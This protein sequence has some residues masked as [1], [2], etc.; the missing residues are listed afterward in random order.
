MQGNKPQ[1]TKWHISQLRI[2]W[3]NSRLCFTIYIYIWY[4]YYKVTNDMI[5]LKIHITSIPFLKIRNWYSYQLWIYCYELQI[6]WWY[7]RFFL[8][9]M[10]CY[11]YVWIFIMISY[12]TIY[13]Q[14]FSYAFNY[15]S[16][17]LLFVHLYY[18][19]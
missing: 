19:I 14:I 6:Q 7:V 2:C 12:K 16:L 10:L 1:I 5:L 15:V 4:K 8:V 17:L 18:S 9:I 11:R 3:K 13:W